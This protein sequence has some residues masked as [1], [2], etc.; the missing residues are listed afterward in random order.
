[1]HDFRW[2][3]VVEGVLA[4]GA[5][6]I[7]FLV[8]FDLASTGNDSVF[9]FR[10]SAFSGQRRSEIADQNDDEARAAA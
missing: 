9:Y 6:K 4:A 7:P 10:E 2:G 3:R 1:M 8:Q 5:A